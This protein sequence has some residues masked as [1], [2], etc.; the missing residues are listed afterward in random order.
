MDISM[1][2]G[3]LPLAGVEEL[4][5]LAG[6][7]VV[8][9]DLESTGFTNAKNFG[10]TEVA[11][12]KVGPDG[13][14]S[15]FETLI[16]P[17]NYFPEDIQIL[18]GIR[19][20]EVLDKR[21]F[22]QWAQHM[23]L[24]MEECLFVGFNTRTSD[25][26]GLCSQM[27]RYGFPLPKPAQALDLRDAWRGIQKPERGRGK[28][29]DVATHYGCPFSGAHRAMADV[30]GTA[31]A[32]NAM[33]R[34]HGAQAIH[35]YATATHLN[36]KASD[37]PAALT[38]AQKEAAAAKKPA[39]A[40]RA[41]SLASE[42]VSSSERAAR[43]PR[44]P[45]VGGGGASR[46]NQKQVAREAVLKVLGAGVWD[47]QK[48]LAHGAESAAALSFAIADLLNEGLV[49]PAQMAN[50]AAQRWLH[51]RWDAVSADANGY[52][53]PMLQKAQELG[54]AAHVDYIQL[55]VAI[56]TRAGATHAPQAG[57]TPANAARPPSTLAFRPP[58]PGRG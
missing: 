39:R 12:W 8:I 23:R 38:R 24:V 14:Q 29:I 7:P 52:L 25:I 13:S 33:I 1:S 55:R 41:T 30:K 32:L 17:E 19:E 37:A 35:E 20:H 9:L 46:A 6:R 16:N 53:K 11:Y 45:R 34:A 50:Q 42:S 26:P 40:P 18:T 21:S 4:A 58:L 48:A 57:A 56:L 27:I 28:L 49:H 44:A 15:S 10:I 2:A 5:R 3:V 51:E 43:A 22:A 54:C 47:E 31:M 36:G